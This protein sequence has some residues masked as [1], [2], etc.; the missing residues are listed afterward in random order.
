LV[1]EDNFSSVI[2]LHKDK[3]H[4]S[5][6]KEHESYVGSRGGDH[7]SE[8]VGVVTRRNGAGVVRVVAEQVGLLQDS[9]EAII[10]EGNAHS[11]VSNLLIF[12][13]TSVCLFRV[14]QCIEGNI[15]RTPVAAT[16]RFWPAT[17]G[18]GEM[19][20]EVILRWSLDVPA[21]IV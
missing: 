2:S 17:G 9:D 11:S 15:P 5:Q 16:V 13:N 7:L 20:T 18:S 6:D 4:Y 10:L 19:V 3:Y 12:C 1:H 8:G 21:L 14:L